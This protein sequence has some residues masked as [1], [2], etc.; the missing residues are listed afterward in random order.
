LER[1]HYRCFKQVLSSD[2]KWAN[3]D[4]LKQNLWGDKLI[5][6]AQKF[7]QDPELITHRGSVSKVL[8][9]L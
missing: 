7:L 4:F 2:P 3:L 1:R 6:E 9:Q 5:I 8:K